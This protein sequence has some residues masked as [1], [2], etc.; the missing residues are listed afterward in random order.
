MYSRII[1]VSVAT[2]LFFFAASAN[3][4]PIDIFIDPSYGSTENTGC[5]GVLTLDFSEVGA[6]DY[7]VL[8]IENTTPI[9]LGSMLTAVGLEMPDP[10][11]MP[12]DFAPGG[13]STYFIELGYD[14]VTPPSWINAPGGYDVT[15]SNNGKFLGGDPNGAPTAGE[16]QTV[17]LNLGDTGLTLSDLAVT[18][19]DFY[20]GHEEPYAIARFQSVGPGGGDS[21]KVGGRV[22][23]PATLVLLVCGGLALRRRW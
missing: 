11:S 12:P 21:D 4:S 19:L 20:T 17:V 7:L 18:F 6:D 8:E 15:I 9:G 14:Q 1:S 3:A 23:E 2:T 13:T 10:P 22:P 5:T 16:S